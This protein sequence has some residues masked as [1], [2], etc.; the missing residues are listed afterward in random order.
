MVEYDSSFELV[1]TIEADALFSIKVEI[2]G[3]S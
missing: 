1:K 2:V 3:V